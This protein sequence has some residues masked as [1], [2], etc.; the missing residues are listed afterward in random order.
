MCVTAGLGLDAAMAQ[1]YEKFHNALADELYIVSMEIRMGVDRER[2][3]RNLAERVAV[4]ELSSWVA[5]LIQSQELGVSM[6]N[7]LRVQADQC[8]QR[9]LQRAEELAQTL[10]IKMLFPMVFLIFPALFIIL[11]GPA[12]L[13]IIETF[14]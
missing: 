4:P 2:A 11:L 14:Y 9:R 3:L 5:I 1:T 13:I 10:S 7:T 12:G 8:R 6:A